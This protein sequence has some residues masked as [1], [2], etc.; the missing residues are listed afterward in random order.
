MNIFFKK[1][2]YTHIALGLVFLTTILLPKI[3]SA[4]CFKTPDGKYVTATGEPC[5]N[6]IITAVPFLRIIPDARS[7]GMGD[8]GIAISSDANALHFNASKLVFA[9]K[10]MGLSLNY[11]PWL[12]EVGAND[13]YL[14]YIAG[15]YQLNAKNAVGLSVRYFHLGEIDFTNGGGTP[16]ETGISKE[17]EFNISFAKKLSDKLSAGLSLKYIHSDLGIKQ[18]V[19]GSNISPGKSIAA[20]LSLTYQIPSLT[21]GFALTNLGQG[22]SYT[23]SSNKDFI[24]ANL[25]L[26]IAWHKNLGETA[27]LTLTTDINKLLVP[28]PNF[29]DTDENLDGIPDYKQVSPLKGIFSSFGDAPG[30]F[31][32]EIRELMISLGTELWINNQFAFRLGY[33]HEDATKG[34]RK[35]MTTGL[36]YTY[37][38]ITLNGSYL[39]PSTQQKNPLTNKFRVGLLFNFGK[40]DAIRGTS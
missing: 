28:T 17:L 7:S 33:F 5:A 16:I 2:G 21:I 13:L 25:G 30:G 4:Q 40:T 14:A 18:M 11:T 31:E 20:D 35:Y 19:G 10:K 15:Y 23:H 3:S 8:A 6:P 22:I 37:K 24:P 29:C 9:D 34:N 36:G 27:R 1:N 12:K 26:G 38:F 32:E 39:I